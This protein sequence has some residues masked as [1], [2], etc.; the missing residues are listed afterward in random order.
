LGCQ[1]NAISIVLLNIA[2]RA[3]NIRRPGRFG[4]RILGDD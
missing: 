1:K 3:G 2:H 4:R